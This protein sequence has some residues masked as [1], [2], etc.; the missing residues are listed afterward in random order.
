MNTI[1]LDVEE[2][3]RHQW[4]DVLSIIIDYYKEEGYELNPE[5]INEATKIIQNIR[6]QG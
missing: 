5:E 1:K 2:A 3:I 4:I 6:I